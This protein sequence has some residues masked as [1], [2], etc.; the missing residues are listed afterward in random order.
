MLVNRPPLIIYS[1]FCFVIKWLAMV[2]TIVFL[3]FNDIST[4][5]Y[6]GLTTLNGCIKLSSGIR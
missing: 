2:Y 1:P 5:E 3:H 6:C 4:R